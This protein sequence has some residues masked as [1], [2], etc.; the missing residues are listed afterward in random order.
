MKMTENKH[1]D[2]VFFEE[3]SI[4]PLNWIIKWGNSVILFFA[5]II[6]IATWYIK[7]P[8]IIVS[9]INIST[10]IPPINIISQTNGRIER[11]FV[12]DKDT[13]NNDGYIAVLENNANFNDVQ[14]LK[15]LLDEIKTDFSS[16]NRKNNYKFSDSLKLGDLQSSYYDLIQS[17]LNYNL[18]KEDRSITKKIGSLKKQISLQ[19]DLNYKLFKEKDIH[20]REYLISNQK[21]LNNKELYEKNLISKDEFTNVENDLLQKENLV[22]NAETQ[23]INNNIQSVEYEKNILDLNKE[24]NEFEQTYLL[25]LKESIKK[26]ENSIKSWEEKYLL[27]SPISGRVC[28]FKTFNVGEYVNANTEIV[29][30]L[31]NTQKLAGKISL[32]LFG[33]GKVKYGQEIII[34]FDNFPFQEYGTIS[35]KIKS[36]SEMPIQNVFMVNVSLPDSLKTNFGKLLE[37]KQNMSG[38]SEIITED[39]NLFERL[40]F[41]IRDLTSRL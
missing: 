33:S 22:L 9:K 14:K 24:F 28:F 36:I 25:T 30:I 23:I 10:D 21:Y 2:D 29:T 11:F 20:Q 13:I 12:T 26:L 5:L 3:I 19:K 4:T 41:K 1:N 18:F 6:L 35:G 31:P 17:Y 34:K 15:I 32:P 37:F 40:F 8:E 38:T 16:S 39:Y 7:Y 27:K